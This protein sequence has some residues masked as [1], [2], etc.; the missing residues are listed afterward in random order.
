MQKFSSELGLSPVSRSRVQAHSP[1]T[2]KPWE[3]ENEWQQ[4]S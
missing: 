1:L 2:R 3:F 4:F